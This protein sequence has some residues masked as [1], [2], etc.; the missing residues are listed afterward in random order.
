MEKLVIKKEMISEVCD[1]KFLKLYD[2][3]HQEGK[4]YFEA[5]RR[6]VDDVVATKP[7]EEWRTMIPDAVTIAIIL[8]LPNSEPKMLFTNEYRYPIGRFVLSPVAGLIDPEDHNEDNPLVCAAIREIKEETGITVKESDN[9]F[10]V[11]PCAFSSPGMTDESNAFLCAEIYLDNLDELNSDGAVG[12]EMFD[13]FELYTKEEVREAFLSGRDKNGN[14]F[15][16][17]TWAVM[18]YFISRE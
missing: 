18:G 1:K 6:K 8:H 4:H 3:Q 15:S 5:T 16:L 17:S 13:G 7:D 10:V 12:T 11:N 2:I 9:I 14:L